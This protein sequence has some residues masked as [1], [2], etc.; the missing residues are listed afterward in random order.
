MNLSGEIIVFVHE[1]EY[2]NEEGVPMRANRYN[3][4][5]SR[6]NA[7]GD[8]VNASLEVLFSKGV[9]E[10]YGLDDYEEGDMFKVVIDDA[11]LTCRGWEDND[12]KARRVLQA[13][14]NSVEDISEYVP[15]AKK[16]AKKP[17]KKAEEKKPA[18]RLHKRRNNDII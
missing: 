7:E 4:S 17:S 14:I 18:K 3:T 1:F 5:V 13:F 15:E 12:G 2:Y 8:Y 10:E 6:L 11:W 9:V 16:Q